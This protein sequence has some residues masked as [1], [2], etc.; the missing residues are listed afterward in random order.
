MDCPCKRITGRITPGA[1]IRATVHGRGSITG[2]VSVSGGSHA[3]PYDGPYEVTPTR[4][5]QVLYTN[6]KQMADDVTV[7]PIPPN[8]GLITYNGS[9]LTVS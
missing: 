3:A 5:T 7:H 8:Y 9:V 1:S 2:T 6:G 4:Y